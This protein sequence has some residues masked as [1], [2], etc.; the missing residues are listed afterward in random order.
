MIW[1]GVEHWR[2]TRKPCS[3]NCKQSIYPG[4]AECLETMNKFFV[5]EAEEDMGWYNTGLGH[6]YMDPL[7]KLAPENWQKAR[8]RSALESKNLA[9]YR[10][11]WLAMIMQIYQ[12]VDKVEL[13]KNQQKQHYCNQNN[14]MGENTPLAAMPA[15][16]GNCEGPCPTEHLPWLMKDPNHSAYLP[17]LL[18]IFP[19][20][21]FIFT[22]RAPADIVPSMAKL[23]VCF[24]LVKH[25]PRAPG[26]TAQ[27]WG[28][29]VLLRMNRYLSSMINFTRQQQQQYGK[30]SNLS[31]QEVGCQGHSTSTSRRH[32]DFNFSTIVQVIPNMINHIYAQFYPDAPGPT[33]EAKQTLAKYLAANE[34]EKH[35]N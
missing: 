25:I 12:H 20:A 15:A 26:T 28:Q 9:K 2:S 13:G 14:I 30:A 10:Y 24:C 11:A 23:F 34:C 4:L 32:L 22:H 6:M 19:D 29:D 3:V 21:K 31:L 16:K 7:M 18:C 35:G 1:R 33:P 27:E 8:G 5:H 17:E